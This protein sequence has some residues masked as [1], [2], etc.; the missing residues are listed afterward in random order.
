VDAL[1]LGVV[2]VWSFAVALA[3]GVAGLVLG[4]LRL[5]VVVTFATGAAE[6]AGANV[7]ISAVS[8]FSSALAHARAGRVS[9]KLF[10][11]MAPPSVAGGIVGGLISGV[12]PERLLLSVIAVVVLLGSVE[13]LR[14]RSATESARP[15]STG[16]LLLNASAIGFFVGVLGGLV[17]LILGTLRLPALLKWAN[18]TPQAA[19]GTNAAV[20]MTVGIGGLI[21]HLPSGIDWALVAVGSAG[22][23]PGALIGARLVGKL[24]E[25]TLLHAIAAVLVIAGL[26]MAVQAAVG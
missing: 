14:Y 11:W 16:M 2:A 7:T 9:W 18:V 25:Q 21:G 8:A 6:G 1:E 22:G 26:A 10:W 15:A 3:G 4:N 17:G 20:G 19:V 24:D 5:P 12:L 13:V 23:I